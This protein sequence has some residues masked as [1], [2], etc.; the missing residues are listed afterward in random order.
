MST[1]CRSR[2]AS[3]ISSSVARNDGDELG[4]QLLDEADRV[5]EQRVAAGGQADAPRHRVQRGEEQVLGEHLGAR[6]GV[7]QR[8]LAGVRVADEGDDLHA[9]PRATPTVQRALLAHGI[10]LAAQLRDPVAH[11]LAVGLELA[12]AGTAGAD[13]PLEAFE[14]APLA[15]Q[16]RQQVLRLRQL[17]L[18]ARLPRLGAPGED[19]DDQRRAVEHFDAERVLQVALLRGAELVVEDD[20]RVAGGL[21]LRDD[22]V[23][24]AAAD[25]VCRVRSFEALDRLPCDLGAGGVSKERQ[26]LERGFGVEAVVVPGALGGRGG[27]A[28]AGVGSCG[29]GF[30]FS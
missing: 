19:V 15:G 8:A 23:E 7:H 10:D 25:V 14:V 12:L 27:R 2:S 22:L 5:G 11:E 17:D 4:R 6:E 13:A 29:S 9:L 18:Q 30:F 1:T 16:A 21:A 28:P 3:V 20:E 26:L 24:L